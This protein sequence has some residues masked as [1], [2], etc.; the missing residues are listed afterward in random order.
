M[1]C[2]PAEP[3][4]PFQAPDAAGEPIVGQSAHRPHQA[5]EADTRRQYIC[6]ECPCIHEISVFKM[7]DSEP[8]MFKLRHAN[9][10]RQAVLYYKQHKMGTT[11]LR[12][13]VDAMLQDSAWEITKRL[14]RDISVRRKTRYMQYMQNIFEVRIGHTT[15]LDMSWIPNHHSDNYS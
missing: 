13:V 2:E 15:E 8:N 3:Q 1:R 4:R 11:L 5:D 6:K 14:R 9:V 12:V 10:I 7:S